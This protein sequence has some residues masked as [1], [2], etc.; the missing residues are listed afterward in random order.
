MS[1]SPAPRLSNEC[2]RA[3]APGGTR[4]GSSCKLLEKIA[5]WQLPSRQI[6]LR[7]ERVFEISAPDEDLNTTELVN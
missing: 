7:S 2:P 1:D 3:V 4:F 6:G 5:A